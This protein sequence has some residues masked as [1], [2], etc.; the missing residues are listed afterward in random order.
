V[1]DVILWGL[2][3]HDEQRRPIMPGFAGTLNDRQ[4]ADLLAYVRARF[5]D[6]PP[7]TDIDKD[8]REARA[9]GSRIYPAPSPPS[10]PAAPGQQEEEARQ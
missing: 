8:I 9:G 5:S 1:I 10:V 2:P 7:W 3:A 4:L 6:K